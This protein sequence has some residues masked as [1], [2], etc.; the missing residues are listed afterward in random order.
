MKKIF[1]TKIFF[2]C[3]PNCHYPSYKTYIDRKRTIIDNNI[4]ISFRS[5]SVSVI[6]KNDNAPKTPIIVIIER[7]SSK[8]DFNTILFFESA[9]IGYNLIKDLI[10]KFPI[11][12]IKKVN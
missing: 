1:S 11:N 5:G 10:I 9:H 3:F 6:E 2:K 4:E 12:L 7:L 8:N